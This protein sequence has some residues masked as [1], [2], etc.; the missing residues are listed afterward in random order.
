MDHRQGDRRRALVPVEIQQRDGQPEAGLVY[1]I[2]QNGMFVV[3]SSRPGVYK[4]V[5]VL[6]PSAGK[7]PTRIPA[8]VVHRNDKGFGLLFRQ[9]EGDAR[10]FVQKYL[11]S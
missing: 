11:R 5:N 4:C 8:M 3:S 7:A 6:L 2:S 1:D 10:T 9:L